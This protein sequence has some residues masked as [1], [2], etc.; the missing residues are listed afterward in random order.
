MTGTARWADGVTLPFR[1]RH[2]W[3]PW[4]TDNVVLG[5]TIYAASPTLNSPTLRHELTHVRQYHERGWWWVW[6]NPTPRETEARAAQTAA[7]PTWE[8]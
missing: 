3:F 2:R 7:W 8:V 6:T 1:V 5:S 4:G